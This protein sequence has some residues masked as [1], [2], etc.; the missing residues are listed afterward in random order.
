MTFKDL[1]KLVQSQYGLEQNQ[2]E[3]RLRNKPFKTKGGCCFNHVIGLPRKDGIEKSIFDYEKLLYDSLLI[4]NP[5]KL[6]FNEKYLWVK[7]ATGL[8]VTELFLR[9]MV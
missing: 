1:Q 6:N 5:S 9:F 4:P 7:K 3:L 8:G 2:L